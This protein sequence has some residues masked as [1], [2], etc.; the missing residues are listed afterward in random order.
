VLK[1]S[2]GLTRLAFYEFLSDI[3][4]MTISLPP[5]SEADNQR[6]KAK[7]SELDAHHDFMAGYPCNQLFDYESVLPMLRHCANNVGDP[8]ADSNFALNTLDFEREVLSQ[9]AQWLNAPKDNFWGYVTSGG[10]EGNMHGLY[11]ARELHPKGIVYYSQDTHYSVT[12]IIHVLGMQSIMIRSL[13]NGEI[14]YDDL[15]ETMKLHRDKPPIIFANIGTT[16]KQAIDSLPKIKVIIQD[17]A[18]T[19][20][21]IHSDCAFPGSYLPFMDNPPEFDFSAGVDSMSISGHKFI[22]SPVPCGM[23]LAKRD[24][25]QRIGRR[26][27]YIGAMDTT[28][29]GSRSAVAPMFLWMAMKRWGAEGF[30]KLAHECLEVAQYAIEKFEEAGV[31]AWRNEHGITVIF[32]RPSDAIIKKWA[33]APECDI[34]HVITVGHVTRDTIDKLCADVLEDYREHKRNFVKQEEQV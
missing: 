17:L 31:P 12:K 33:L 28:I 18:I 22:G 10:T 6:L 8:W 19:Q 9:Y 24:N 7:L 34:V 14:D 25:V 27:E 20:F 30:K 11:V 29:P 4:R 2:K 32:P 3:T 15:R 16:M 5:L 1:A 23:V 13:E 26:I 21:Y